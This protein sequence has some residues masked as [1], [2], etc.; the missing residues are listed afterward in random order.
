MMG[1][2]QQYGQALYELAVDE[3]ISEAI[4]HQS[5]TL[6]RSFQEEPDFLRLLAS[7]NLSKEERCSLLDDSFRN[8]LHPYLLNF[9]KILTREGIVRKF[10]DCCKY[11]EDRYYADNGFLPVVAWTAQPLTPA[12]EHQLAEKMEA[13]TGKRVIL[14]N[15]I[16]PAC[17][18]GVRLSYDGKQVDGTVQ[19]RLETVSKL[20]KNTVL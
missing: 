19:H 20:L 10:P 18:G 6:Y 15:R 4:F 3:G 12:Q 9:L 11:I 2:A 17:L 14:Q 5:Q 1:I 13:V 7:V 16:D 8:K